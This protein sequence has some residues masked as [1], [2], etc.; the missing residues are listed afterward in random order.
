MGNVLEHASASLDDPEVMT[1]AQK[2]LR[3]LAE[4]AR[5]VET[6]SHLCSVL[7]EFTAVA[8]QGKEDPKS[9]CLMMR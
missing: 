3:N 1:Q 6:L 5:G 8:L 4:V 9:N 2:V 7:D